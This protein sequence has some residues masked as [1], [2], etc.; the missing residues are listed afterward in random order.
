MFWKLVREPF[1]RPRSRRRALWAVLAIALGT[2]VAAA[3]LSVSLDVG[4][5]IGNE[6][7]SLGANIV[8]TPAADSLPVEIGGIDYRPIS[9][10]AYIA[11]SSLPRLKQIFWGNNIIAFAP[12][13]YVPARAAAAS[14]AVST[15]LV[16][17]WFDYPLVLEKGVA[18]PTGIQALNPTWQFQGTLPADSVHDS[19]AGNASAVLGR[20]LAAKLGVGLG[21]TVRL[22]RASDQ[23]AGAA[24]P[25]ALRVAA[26]LTTGGSEEDQIFAPLT[27]V[28]A[29]SGLYGKVRTV[30]VSALIKPDDELSRKGPERMTPVE[31]DRWYCSPYIS[32]ILHQIDEALPGTSSK[33]VRQVA[34]TQGNVLGKLTFLMG[35]L[36]VVA[37][38]AAGLGISSLASL[39]VLE[40]REE[41]GLMKALGAGSGMVAGFFLTEMAAQGFLGG[42]LGFAA[43]HYLAKVLGQVVFGT[44]VEVHW[45]VLPAMLLVALTVSFAGT[46]APV[47]RAVREDPA[48]VLRSA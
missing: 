3:M 44:A 16:G 23:S 14:S 19:D 29:W 30:Q 36:A 17:T 22:A 25:L 1:R 39:T 43:G 28:Q 5:R 46:L 7:R 10:G 38:L 34:E 21:G 15:T 42:L 6:M 2:A 27:V 40:R 24:A 4:D 31:Y 8:I 32:S 48:R 26:I 20:S 35:L 41:I 45:L 9:E 47:L 12:Y 11:E 33:A 13:L 18:F 37:L